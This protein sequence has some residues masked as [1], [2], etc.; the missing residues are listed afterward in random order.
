MRWVFRRPRMPS[1]LCFAAIS[2]GP[3]G[4]PLPLPLSHTLH[5]HLS[6]SPNL[7]RQIGRVQDA[8]EAC[9]EETRSQF[10]NEIPYQATV[11]Y[12]DGAY[13]QTMGYDDGGEEEEEEEGTGES[14]APADGKAD[15]DSEAVQAE[16][17]PKVPAGEPSGERC[18][19]AT[20]EPSVNFP[21]APSLGWD[22]SPSLVPEG[23]E[24]C[25]VAF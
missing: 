3:P 8:L 10:P 14:G 7:F 24:A 12:N 23:N 22:T 13:Q 6:D 21:C 9:I 2:H 15:K 4:L 17:V 11:A 18:G 1:S 5:H 20:P 16:S 19:E 25:I